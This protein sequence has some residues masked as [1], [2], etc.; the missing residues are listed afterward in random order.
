MFIV[1]EGIR[2]SGKST[3]AQYLWKH[4]GGISGEDCVYARDPGG[5]A[6]AEH[7]REVLLS[8]DHMFAWDPMAKTLMHMA[9]RQQ[10]N[11]KIIRPGLEEGK[12]IVCDRYHPSMYVHQRI[13]QDSDN[14]LTRGV[15][16]QLDKEMENF[17]TPD[18]IFLLTVRLSLALKRKKL[19]GTE[20]HIEELRK[21]QATYLQ[22]LPG[23]KLQL[24]GT[25]I[26]V[27]DGSNEETEIANSI[28]A[29]YESTK[30]HT[31]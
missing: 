26:Y 6:E 22:L 9:A 4:I 14:F 1:F 24:P 19:I 29:I 11:N 21:E 13:G 8:P 17:I 12:T 16:E 18:I 23:G 20:Q 5:P 25:H 2:G 7:I 28:A 30:D 15:V 3:Q 10:L 31:G 27:I